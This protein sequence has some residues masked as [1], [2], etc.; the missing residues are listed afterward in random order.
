M[1]LVTGATGLIG[2]HLLYKL[3]KEGKPVLAAKRS[4]SKLDGVKRV[5]YYYEKNYFL[6]EAISWIEID[7]HDTLSLEEV[8]DTVINVYHCAG[9]VSFDDKDYPELKKENE[10]LTANLVN[11]CLHKNIKAFCYVSSITVINNNDYEGEL[12][13]G[14]FWKT[15]G[16]ESAYA[17]SKYNAEREVWRAMEEGLNSIIVNPG[18]VIGVGFEKQSSGKMIA[19]CSKGSRFYP[20]GKTG[21]VSACDV[22]AIMIK[23]MEKQ[24]FDQR[25]IVIENMY[26]FQEIFNRLNQYFGHK[27]PSYKAGSFLLQLARISDAFWCMISRQKRSITSASVKSALSKK[28]YSNQ[29]LANLLPYQFQ[30]TENALKCAAEELMSQQKH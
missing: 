17:I 22:A 15:S 26:P 1:N 19:L 7:F 25:Y 5:F 14:V 3:M 10:T 6:F 21:F 24:A 2:S 12:N 29:K 9:M 30:K 23:L 13:E 11:A 16:K 18:V 4:Q 28:S 27:A 8:L 20:P